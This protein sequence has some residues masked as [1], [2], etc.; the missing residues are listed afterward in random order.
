[1]LIGE[2]HQLW[3]HRRQEHLTQETH[4]LLRERFRVV[5]TL[6]RSPHL[7]EHGGRIVIDE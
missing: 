6:H 3:R 1:M 2:L 7:R 4:E 5:S